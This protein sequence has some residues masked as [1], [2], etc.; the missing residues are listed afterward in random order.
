MDLDMLWQMED[1]FLRVPQWSTT[2]PP[3]RR[4]P[5]ASKV[6]ADEKET[7]AGKETLQ[8]TDGN[9]FSSM[10]SLVVASDVTDSAAAQG[11]GIDESD[12]ESSDYDGEESSAYDSEE[13]AE[14]RDLLREAMDIA[15]AHPEIFEERK[16]F[17]ERSN[18]N[19][20]LKALGALRGKY[21][22]FIIARR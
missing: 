18:D 22:D 2:V 21:W 6:F 4:N 9:D 12:D 19:Q 10:P 14:L 1:E 17:E 11:E 15:S 7:A 3:D 8:I 5:K 20:F 16:A 13:E